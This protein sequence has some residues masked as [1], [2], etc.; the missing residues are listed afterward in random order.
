MRLDGK[1]AAITGSA[2]GIGK[3]I[4]L[5][6]ARAGGSFGWFD[7][8]GGP[9]YHIDIELDRSLFSGLGWGVG[10]HWASA[11]CAND[12]VNGTVPVPEPTTMLLLGSGLVGLWGARKKFKK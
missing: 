8:L 9:D 4:A 7:G 1:L 6:F 11:T 10:L 5:C 3:E 2:M 12:Y